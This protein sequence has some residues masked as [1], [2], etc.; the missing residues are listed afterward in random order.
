LIDVTRQ[1]AGGLASMLLAD[2]GAETVRVASHGTDA[3]PHPASVAWRRN[4][5]RVALDPDRPDDRPALMELIGSAD[6]ALF[7]ARPGELESLELD[8]RTLLSRTPDLLHVWMPPYGTEGRWSQLPP[9]HGLLTAVTGVAFMQYSYEDQPIHL[10]S[11]QVSYGQALLAACATASALYDRERSGCGAR[12]TVNGIDAVAAIKTGTLIDADE[13]LPLGGLRSS[14]GAGPNYRLYQCADGRWLFLG[15]LRA[16]FFVRALEL[17]DM[18]ELFTMPGVEGDFTQFSVAP[19][20]EIAVERLE[21]RFA[22]RDRDDWLQVLDDPMVPVSPVGSR[23]EW[24]SSETIRA[25]EMQVAM[26]HP[27]LGRVEMPGTPLKL[28]AASRARYEVE[29]PVEVAALQPQPTRPERAAARPERVAGG[30]LAGIR[31]LDVATF[32]AGAFTSTVL[33]NFGAEIAKIEPPDGD[34]WRT[35]GLGFIAWNRGKRSA[36][37]DLKNDDGRELFFDLVRRADVVVDNYRVGV[38]ERLGLDYERLRSINPRIV[39]CSVTAYGPTG[40]LAREPG[41][42]TVVQARSGLMLTQG[43][44]D[45]PVALRMSPIDTAT[46]ITAAFGIS[47]ALHERERTGEGQ[48]VQ[49]SL[50][51]LSVFCQFAELVDY[52]GRPEAVSGGRDFIGPS[53]LER[54]YECADGWVAVQATAAGHFEELCAALGHPEWGEQSGQ[55]PQADGPLADAIGDAL[56]SLTRAEAVER[57]G[58]RD[59]PVAP[60]IRQEEILHDPFLRQHKLLD[61]YEHPDH[62]TVSGIRGYGSIDETRLGFTRRAP[63]LGEHTTELLREF[64]VEGPRIEQLLK[65][66]II[67]QGG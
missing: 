2:L 28:S 47:A 60:A 63:L 7:D 29:R 58:A 23:E 27:D 15:C 54:F 21:A 14:R 41:F 16:P 53:A 44:H 10:A 1:P 8:A 46:A 34:P 59:V 22:E 17:M 6:V 61:R 50:A 56:R 31:V 49:T 33:A 40:P 62:G 19:Y 66:E 12:L 64:G 51:E 32:I 20:N 38:R 39:T 37:L 48:E 3:E 5:Q 52:D 57:L 35:Q 30:P 45:E 4:R 26:E 67:R 24:F 36:V 65:D 18:L 25:N 11:P 55:A 43:G 9:D 42:D 13:V